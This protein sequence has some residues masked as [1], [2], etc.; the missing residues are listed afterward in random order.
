MS[1]NEDTEPLPGGG[2]PYR[3]TYLELFFDLVFV[4]ALA[5]LAHGLAHDLTWRGLVETLVTLLALWWVWLYTVWMTNRLG[6][7]RPVIQIVVLWTMFASLLMAVSALGAFDERSVVFAAAYMAVQIGRTVVLLAAG[8]TLRDFE[9]MGQRI[10]ALVVV[11]ATTVLLWRIYFCHAG[12]LLPTTLEK[13]R[14]PAHVGLLASYAHLLMV[15]GILA[16]AVGDVISI[17]TPFGHAELAS[18]AAILGGPALFLFGRA[19][20]DYLTFQHVAWS[21]LVGVLLLAAVMPAAV[22]NVRS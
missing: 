7:G 9:F 6:Q 18:V 19:L 5:Q 16:T 4:F 10:L 20:L 2:K 11:F 22:T 13:A 21:R 12:I 14:H 17:S 1:A 3:A 8:L 15:G